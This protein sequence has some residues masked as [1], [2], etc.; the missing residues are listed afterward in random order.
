MKICISGL[1]GSGKN[2]VGEKLAA[3]LGLRLINPTFKTLA[4]K[5]KITL[6][7]FHKKAEKDHEIDREFDRHLVEM[8]R[9]GN[10][11]I[12][13]WLG[14]WMIK[15]AD[16]RIWLYAP[17]SAR[18]ARVASRDGISLEE[19]AKHIAERDE[20]N[21]MRYL[22]IYRI[23]IYDHSGFDLVINTERFLPEQS[24]EI[25]AA[26]AEAKMGKSRGGKQGKKAAIKKKRGG[27]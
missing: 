6:L 16:L 18:A 2:S 4:A 8:A 13:T 25:I 22:E 24:A 17:S 1:S 11:V 19:A 21:R 14:P 15:D 12:T 7:D 5:Q 9:G 3:R 26:A 27:K 23:D 10:C 20:S